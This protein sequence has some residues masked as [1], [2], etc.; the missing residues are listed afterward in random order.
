MSGTFLGTVKK[1]TAENLTVPD[2]KNLKTEVVD[3]L[4]KALKDIANS[5]EDFFIIKEYADYITV[6]AKI[7]LPTVEQEVDY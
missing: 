3:E 2:L 6:G 1:I 7:Y 5:N 4:C